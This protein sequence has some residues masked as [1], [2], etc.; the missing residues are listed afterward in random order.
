MSEPK[1]IATLIVA[2]T[3]VSFGVAGAEPDLASAAV[4]TAAQQAAR[5]NERVRI[6]H[7]ELLR[8]QAAA[9]EAVKLR[10]ERLAAADS[11]GM[12]HAEQAIA[13][14]ATNIAALQREL[15]QATRPRTDAPRAAPGISVSRPTAREP[16]A[17]WD[18]YAKSSKRTAS[19]ATPPTA[20][21][22]ATNDL[23]LDR[24]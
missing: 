17:W 22:P 19:T 1:R 21:P 9:S 6:L 4:V 16:G 13:R 18:V 10:A 8:E 3:V 11:N 23:S 12:Q 2:S 7:V 14:A 15:Q 20:A 5:D 24:H